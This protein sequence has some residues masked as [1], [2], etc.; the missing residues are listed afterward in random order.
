MMR[1]N[2]ISYIAAAS[3]ILTPALALAQSSPKQKKP[4]RQACVIAAGIAAECIGEPIP[5]ILEDTGPGAS[6]RS[7]RYQGDGPIVPFPSR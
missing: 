6:R 1:L 4:P 7:Y 5:S 2:W 3:M